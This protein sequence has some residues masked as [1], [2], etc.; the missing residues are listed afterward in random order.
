MSRPSKTKRKREGRKA[1]I[2]LPPTGD[3]G[4]GTDAANAQT[5]LIPVRGQEHNRTARRQRVEAWKRISFTMRQAQAAQALRDA[6]CGVESL[7]SGGPL[8]ERVQSSPKPDQAI[9]I[10]VAKQSR[11]IKLLR[12]VPPTSRR[13]VDHVFRENKPLR[14]LD[15]TPRSAARLRLALDRVAD[16]MGC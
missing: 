12:A 13:V 6:Y 14:A 11:L 7:A 10:Q 4:T 5:L 8:K 15:K 1:C 3:H 2:S 9:D 16:H